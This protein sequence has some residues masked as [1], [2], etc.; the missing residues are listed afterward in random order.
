MAGLVVRDARSGDLEAMVGLLQQLFGIEQDFEPAPE[1]QRRGLAL[2]LARGGDAKLLVA[3]VDGAV[4][5]ML[6]AQVGVSTAEGARV[7]VLEDMIVDSACR[8]RGVGQALLGAMQAWAEGQGM[9]RLQ[10]L[11][12]A[13]NQPAL[14]FYARQGWRTTRLIALRKLPA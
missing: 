1:K 11:A 3:E 7:A 6:T 5:G 2:L 14:D 13:D 9:P 10:L 8:G 4:V 12:D